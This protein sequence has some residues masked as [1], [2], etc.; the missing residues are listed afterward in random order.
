VSEELPAPARAFADGDVDLLPSAL[1]AAEVDALVALLVERADAARLERLAGS[2][3][4]ALAKPA[5][6][7]LHVLR[8]RG[9]KVP[10][11]APLTFRVRGPY[12]EEAQP[13]SVASGTDGRGERMLFFVQPGRDGFDVFQARVSEER[14][15]VDFVAGAM[16]RKDWR[17]HERG[18]LDEPGLGAARISGAHARWL[19]ERAYQ[20]SVAE[21]RALPAAFVDARLALGPAQAPERH[22]A[23]ALAPPLSP[24]EARPRLAELATLDACA[25]WLPPAALLD[26]LELKIGEIATSRLIVD[27][28]QRSEQL[29]SAIERIAD[30]AL[31]PGGP[32]RARLE[33]RLLETAYLLA[34]RGRVDDA[35]LLTAAAALTADQSISGASNPLVVALFDRLIDRKK[36]LSGEPSG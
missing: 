23:L 5:R 19:I 12:A 1:S 35:R 14:G 36:L 24:D 20:Q 33:E 4:K 16:S 22:P 3:D 15:L 10:A 17:V 9:A 6:R 7:G 27:P 31:D 18:I 25:G 26:E 8:T 28:A 21:K 13:P 2:P 29:T 32:F 34:Q 30:R 11:P